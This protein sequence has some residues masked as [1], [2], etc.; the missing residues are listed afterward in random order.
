MP[1]IL[2]KVTKRRIEMTSRFLGLNKRVLIGKWRK[3]RK[4]KKAEY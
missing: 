3:I 1:E 4:E 2:G